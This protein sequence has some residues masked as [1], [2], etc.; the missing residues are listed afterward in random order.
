MRKRKH[1]VGAIKLALVT[2]TSG[3]KSASEVANVLGVTTSTIYKC[4]L[5]IPTI[6]DYESIRHTGREFCL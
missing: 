5:F 2:L 3:L 4:R 1:G 6:N